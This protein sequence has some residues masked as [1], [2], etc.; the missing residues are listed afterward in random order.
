MTY[1]H[2]DMGDILEYKDQITKERGKSDTNEINA[3][4]QREFKTEENPKILIV[5]DMLITGFDAPKLKVM[6]LDKPLYEHRLLQAIARVNRPYKDEIREKRYG[7]IVDSIGLLKYVRESIEKYGLVADRRIASDIEDN[8]LGTIESGVEE[9]KG[10]LNNLKQIMKTLTIDGRDLSIDV[11]EIKEELKSSKERALETIRETVDPKAKI[12]AALWS[13]P[14]MQNL[15]NMMKETIGQFEALGSHRERIYYVEDIQILVYIYGM[16]VNYIKGKKVP[17]EFWEG[18]IELIHE[19]TLVEEFRTLMKA[20]ISNEMLKSIL[21]GA[22]KVISAGEIVQEQTVA[23]AYNILSRLLEMDLANPIYRE[24]KERIEAA[25]E[26]WINRNMDTPTFLRI[27]TVSNDERLRYEE[28]IANKPVVERITETVN[29]LANEKFA[30]K[31]EPQL[32]LENLKLENLKKEIPEV[33][34]AA[35]IVEPHKKKLR[36]ALMKDLFR[37]IR[38]ADRNEIEKFVEDAVETY[39]IKEIEKAR[40]TGEPAS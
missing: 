28:D 40:K 15:L 21:H 12:M 19:K 27:L 39:I 32:K 1:Q 9:F 34:R 22:S 11:D 31:K 13:T 6:Y 23:D 4:I 5:T 25:R 17:Q 35:K 20:E 30:G 7:L 33:M 38:E 8:A 16:V 24:I 10:D 37:E 26:E 36:T 29:L 18:L 14:E 3:D 2:N